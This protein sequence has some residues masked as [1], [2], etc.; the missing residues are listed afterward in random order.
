MELSEEIAVTAV[1]VANYEFHSSA[2]R[3]FEV[4]GTS[5]PADKEDGYRLILEAIADQRR[6]PQ[7]FEV[8][9]RGAPGGGAWSKHV[10]FKFTSHYG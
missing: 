8:R 1:T 3:A 7:T 2:P 10:K 5:G 9:Q 6:E 4:W